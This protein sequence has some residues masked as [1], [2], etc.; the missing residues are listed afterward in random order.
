MPDAREKNLATNLDAM[1]KAELLSYRAQIEGE[2][3]S[4]YCEDLHP[5]PSEIN[6]LFSA[7][8]GDI[9]HTIDSVKFR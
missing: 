5:L 3:E 4:L 6:D 1:K 7:V 2:F 9:F 8:L